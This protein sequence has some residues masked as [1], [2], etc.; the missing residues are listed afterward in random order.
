[1]VASSRHGLSRF[2]PT[3]AVF[4]APPSPIQRV[5]WVHPLLSSCSSSEPS[6]SSSARCAHAPDHLPWSLVLLATSANKSAAPVPSR[7]PAF[8]PNQPSVLSVPPALDGLLLVYFRGFVSLH[9]HLRFLFRG[10]SRQSAVSGFPDR[11]LHVVDPY[12]LQQPKSLHQ[13]QRVS[14]SRRLSDC[15]FVLSSWPVTANPSFDPL[16]SFQPPQV[17]LQTP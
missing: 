11:C 16:L 1:L 4:R 15:R 3:C 17:F 14:P 6:L 12:R 9:S 13:R 7:D 5:K 10:F 2:R 8:L